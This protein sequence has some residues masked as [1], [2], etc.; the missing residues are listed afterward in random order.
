MRPKY[1]TEAIVLARIPFGEASV[2]LVLL[3]KEFGVVKARAQGV[4]KMGAKLA[5][6]TQTG[7]ESDVILVRG[8]DGWRLSGALLVHNWFSLFN[9]ECRSR[10]ARVMQ[11]LMRF[12]QGESHDPRLYLILSGLLA[13]LP[14]LVES[15]ADAAECLAALRLLHVLGLDAGAI[16]GGMHEYTPEILQTIHEKRRAYIERINHGIQASGL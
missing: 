16:P 12:V 3:T 1:A 4:R 15:E 11:L 6:A 13:T 5:S 7:S 9:G 8:K 10:S 14:V 2:Q